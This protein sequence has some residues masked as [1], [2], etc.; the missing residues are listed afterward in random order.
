MVLKVR[1]PQTEERALMQRG[2]VLI[3][4]LEPFND[5]GIAAMNAAGLTAFALPVGLLLA[6]VASPNVAWLFVATSLGYFLNYEFLHMAYHLRPDH[7]IAR[8]ALV[9]RLE[10]LH[11]AH[12]DPTLM[13]RRNFN[14]TYPICDALF[15]T[16]QRK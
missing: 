11:R 6:W 14:I 12:H 3:G 4:M 15:G 13:A 2:A 9:R 8:W 1:S 7:P 5:A 10:P 16:L